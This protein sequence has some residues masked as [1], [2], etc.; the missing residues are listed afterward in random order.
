MSLTHDLTALVGPDAEP[1]AGLAPATLGRYVIEEEIGQGA[2][3][4]VYRASDP[5]LDRRVAL[6][7]IR[8]PLAMSLEE[9]RMAE[10]RFLREASLAAS[11]SHPNSVVVHDFGRDEETDLPFIAFEYLQGRSLTDVIAN[12]PRP[13]WREALAITERLAGA[14][15]KAHQA[16]VIHR[17]VKPGNV[18]LLESGEPKILDFGIAR[19]SS[20]E[21]TGGGDTWGTPS[22]MSPEQVTGGILDPRSDLFSLG[23]VCFEL[24]TGRQ[25]F[26]GESVPQIVSRIAF[27]EVPRPSSLEPALSRDVDLLL[28]RAL[29]R[30]PSQRYASGREFAEDI[31]DVLEGRRLRERPGLAVVA[32]Q[33]PSWS[34]IPTVPP[35]A[36][37][38]RAWI[39]PLSGIA[40]AVAI[41][42]VG[43]PS[44]T[45]TTTQPAPIAAAASAQSFAPAVPLVSWVAQA[46]PKPP[47]PPARVALSVEHRFERGRLRVFVDDALA[48]DRSLSGRQTRHLLL[49]KRRTGSLGE[50]LVVPPGQRLL[51]FEIDGD[52]TRHTGRL[53]G[54]FRSDQT[55]LLRLKAGKRVDLEWQT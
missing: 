5:V 12:G 16:G 30:D 7:V 51:R 4:T 11:I 8:L 46:V 39:G 34:G 48:L 26:R 13:H 1:I 20:A 31:A 41:L 45:G 49:L 38:T 17:D 25:A 37:R 10:Q 27:G 33:N 23:S 42:V 9:R 29:A 3:G 43:L 44:V 35:P 2:M 50:V 18:M 36:R 21:L 54:A 28:A 52:G 53:R 6:K 24:L 40:A 32:P 14:L 19:V 22:Y 15:H 47:P 55:R